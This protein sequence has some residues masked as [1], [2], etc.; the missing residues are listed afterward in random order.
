MAGWGCVVDGL[1]LLL[2]QWRN[3]YRGTV[4]LG[5]FYGIPIGRGAQYRNTWVYDLSMNGAN[6]FIGL[7]VIS[8]RITAAAYCLQFVVVSG[9]YVTI[10]IKRL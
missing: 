7:Q 2:L 8:N 4:I 10:W 6:L 1:M 5:A 9:R 3:F